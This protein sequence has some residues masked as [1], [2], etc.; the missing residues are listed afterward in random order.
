MTKL[1]E[2]YKKMTPEQRKAVTEEISDMMG[3]PKKEKMRKEPTEDEIEA[4]NRYVDQPGQWINTTPPEVRAR[5]AEAWKR[6][7]ESIKNR[8]KRRVKFL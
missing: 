1:E 3:I 7:E 4:M 8:N 5:Q 6:L 2:E